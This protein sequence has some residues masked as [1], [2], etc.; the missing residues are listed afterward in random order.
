MIQIGSY[1]FTY[2]SNDNND[3]TQDFIFCHASSAAMHRGEIASTHNNQLQRPDDVSCAPKFLSLIARKISIT[4][5]TSKAL[6][7]I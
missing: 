2:W 5:N 4:K 3:L 7:I 6:A 1:T